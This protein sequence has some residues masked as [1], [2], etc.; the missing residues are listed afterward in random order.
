MERMASEG[1]SEVGIGRSGWRWQLADRPE[2]KDEA[3]DS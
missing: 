3:G 2:H 1:E